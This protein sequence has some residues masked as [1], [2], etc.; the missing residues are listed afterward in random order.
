MQGKVAEEM[1]IHPWLGVPHV[2]DRTLPEYKAFH[3]QHWRV[4]FYSPMLFDYM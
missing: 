3:F 1:D 4:L 2:T